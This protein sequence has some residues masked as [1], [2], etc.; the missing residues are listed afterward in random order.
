[1]ESVGWNTAQTVEHDPGSYELSRFGYDGTCRTEIC[2]RG[3]QSLRPGP[4]AL[5]AA[6]SWARPSFS[7]CLT[8]F[9]CT[10]VWWHL[11]SLSDFAS[12]TWWDWIPWIFKEQ[13]VVCHE[14]VLVE[15][16]PSS[17]IWCFL[18]FGNKWDWHKEGAHG[19]FSTKLCPLGSYLVL[20]GTPLHKSL[21]PVQIP[22]LS[23]LTESGLLRAE[24]VSWNN[25]ARHIKNDRFSC[26]YK[27]KA[28][29][30]GRGV[31]E[32]LDWKVDKDSMCI[33]HKIKILW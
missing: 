18:Q 31:I 6:C 27:A 7:L 2:E 21:T 23:N 5:G 25:D 29:S 28:F 9:A 19:A 10:M 14:G 12:K 8:L 24:W 3:A 30:R 26:Y 13:Q 22:T 20:T 15:Y 11:L 16:V 33:L 32:D 1:M 4:G 17:L